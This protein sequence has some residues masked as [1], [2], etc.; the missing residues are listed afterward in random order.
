MGSYVVHGRITCMLLCFN[1]LARAV[2]SWLCWRNCWRQAILV[3]FFKHGIVKQVFILVIPNFF[4]CSQ[5]MSAPLC[6]YIIS[7][8]QIPLFSVL[9]SLISAIAP[10]TMP[11]QL[12]ALCNH[13]FNLKVIIVICQFWVKFYF[14]FQETLFCPLILFTLLLCFEVIISIRHI[15]ENSIMYYICM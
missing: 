2:F 6:H 5:L 10:L 13:N 14:F 1:W 3:D 4:H 12:A 15:F 7:S 8:E 11:L 9:I